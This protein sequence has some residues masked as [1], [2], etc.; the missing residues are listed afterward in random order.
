MSTYD[1]SMMKMTSVMLV[2]E[3]DVI[4]HGVKEYEDCYSD[5]HL[6]QLV[7]HDLHV[8]LAKINDDDDAHNG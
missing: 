6:D 2:M 4:E 3:K 5:Q 1:Q 8:H 7:V